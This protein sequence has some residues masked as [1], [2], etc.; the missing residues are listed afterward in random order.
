M[1]TLVDK[2]APGG[3]QSGKMFFW[4]AL[5]VFVWK[6]SWAEG[7][8]QPGGPGNEA[9]WIQGM[10]EEQRQLGWEGCGRERNKSKLFICD[11]IW[12]P[13]TWGNIFPSNI[14]TRL[15]PGKNKITTDLGTKASS[16]TLLHFTPK[17]PVMKAI[18]AWSA[19]STGHTDTHGLKGKLSTAAVLLKKRNTVWTVR[20]STMKCSWQKWHQWTEWTCQSRLWSLP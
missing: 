9:D 8:M 1:A 10:E 13:L 11:T 14:Q 17:Y 15:V 3:S 5:W 19:F 18:I 20:L 6:E 12:K 16:M 2:A 7:L 4:K